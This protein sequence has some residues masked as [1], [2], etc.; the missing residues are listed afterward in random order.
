M[1]LLPLPLRWRL[2]CCRV[3]HYQLCKVCNLRNF[4]CSFSIDVTISPSF[5]SFTQFHNFLSMLSINLLRTVHRY[6]CSDIE[7][8][9]WCTMNITVVQ[10]T[11]GLPYGYS[12]YNA[13]FGIWI[14]FYYAHGQWLLAS[15][16]ATDYYCRALAFYEHLR[17]QILFA[18]TI[19]H[20]HLT[21]A[22]FTIYVQIFGFTPDL[23]CMQ[24][25]LLGIIPFLCALFCWHPFYLRYLC[26]CAHINPS[27]EHKNPQNDTKREYFI[28]F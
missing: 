21:I 26:E 13:I 16:T 11:N 7:A 27:K 2:Q 1:A 28:D 6:C 15:A 18:W 10:L 12:T 3:C 17:W 25:F 23:Y 5:S 9:T 20:T 4:W 24:I 19:E 22:P 8:Y 14:G